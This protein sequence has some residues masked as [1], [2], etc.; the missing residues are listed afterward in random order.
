MSHHATAYRTRSWPETASLARDWRQ[1]DAASAADTAPPITPLQLA[2]AVPFWTAVLY[3]WLDA[4]WGIALTISLAG[5]LVLLMGRP[6]RYP[7]EATRL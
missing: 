1:A 2:L 4:G 3:G 6:K 7:H 5:A